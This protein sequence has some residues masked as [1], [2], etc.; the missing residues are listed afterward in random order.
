MIVRMDAKGV[1]LMTAT[2]TQLVCLRTGQ[3]WDTKKNAHCD[4]SLHLRNQPYVHNDDYLARGLPIGTDVVE[5]ACRP[6]VKDRMKHAS[7]R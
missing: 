2:A 4:L 7:L 3:K 1:P 6:L 5:G